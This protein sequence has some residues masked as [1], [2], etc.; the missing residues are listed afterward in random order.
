MKLLTIFLTVVTLAFGAPA[1]SGHRTFTQPDGTIIHYQLKGDEYLHW[2]ETREGD[3][4]LYNEKENCLEYAQIKD[5]VLVSS[6]EVVSSPQERT[7]AS[8]KSARLKVSKKELER[9]HSQQRKKWHTH[10]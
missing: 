8:N 3:I 1:F 5:G 10:H 6:G 2:L 9:I 4:V 7:A